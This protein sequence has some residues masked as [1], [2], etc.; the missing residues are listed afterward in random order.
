MNTHSLQ[1]SSLFATAFALALGGAGQAFGSL[2]DTYGQTNLVSDLPGVAAATDPSLVNPWGLVASGTSPWWI[3]DNGSG[4]STLYTGAGAKLGLTVTIQ[5]APGGTVPA[6]P[7]GI[8]FNGSS[9]FGG[10]HFI[11]DTEDGTIAGWSGGTTAALTVNQFPNSVFKG[12]TLGSSGGNTYLYATD[13]RQGTVDVF[14][15]SFGATTL[16]GSF[17]DPTL[18]AGY[19]PFNIANINGDLY[20]TYALQDAAKHDDVGGLG[21]GYIDVFSSDGTFLRRL[22]SNGPLDS[23][24]GLAVA[25]S[26]FGDF[27]NDLLVGNF[28]NGE[29][30]AFNPMTGAFDGTLDD[31]HGNPLAIQGLW[32]LDFGNGSGSGPL[33]TLYFTA[34]IPGPDQVESHGLFG[35]L[36]T[37]P[38]SASSAALLVG[39]LLALAIVAR[40]RTSS[41]IAI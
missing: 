33:N 24:W 4:V 7:T 36:T 10:D 2:P 8:V 21:N 17:S 15:T 11:F 18:P 20:V 32:G 6:P 34:G 41:S 5:P 25:P 3:A 22:V 30:N 37:V 38:E 39:G 35:T 9:G 14:N 12:L 13:F 40:R 29:I 1:R 19:A 27:S 23:P 26:D 31:T 28:G 16:A